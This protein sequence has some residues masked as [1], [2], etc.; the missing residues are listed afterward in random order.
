MPDS[1]KINDYNHSGYDLPDNGCPR[2]P[3]DSPV[4]AKDKQW[5]QNR[6][7]DC[8]RQHTYHGICRASVRPNQMI[9]S[10]C[11][12]QEGYS[13]CTDS[14]IILCI[15]QHLRRYTTYLQNRI[16]KNQ[17]N[18]CDYHSADYQHRKPRPGNLC[19]AFP[20]ARPGFQVKVRSAP[21]SQKKG[22]RR[23]YNGYRKCKFV[24]AFPSIPTP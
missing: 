24:A 18:R 8:S 6:I 10:C 21:D 11:Q 9:S 7:N 20:V 19:R 1:C 14:R 4:E 22:G 2:R 17:D 13:D 15:R 16:Q 5:V 3:L 23:T 12:N